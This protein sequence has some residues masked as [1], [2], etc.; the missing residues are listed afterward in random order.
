MLAVV[1]WGMTRDIKLTDLD[2]ELAEWHYPIDREA[3]VSAGRD[4][5]LVLSEGRVNLGETIADSSGDA[6]DTPDALRNEIMS[7][8]PRHAVGEPYQSE[9]EG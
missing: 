6:F 3:A 1:L 5:T 9:G 4:V 2:A 8:L 7:R